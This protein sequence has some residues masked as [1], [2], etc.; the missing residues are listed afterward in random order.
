MCYVEDVGEV[1]EVLVLAELE[2]G[3]V[4]AVDVDDRR[5]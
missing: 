4:G 2:A 1:E 3:F 5:N